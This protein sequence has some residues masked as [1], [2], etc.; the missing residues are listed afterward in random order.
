MT[1]SLKVLPVAI[2]D[3]FCCVIYAYVIKMCASETQHPL[4]AFVILMKS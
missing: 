1:V 4:V 2:L 3:C